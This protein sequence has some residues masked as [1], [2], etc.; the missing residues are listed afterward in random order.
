MRTE[1]VF[2]ESLLMPF[3]PQLSRCLLLSSLLA[4]LPLAACTTV[5]PDYTGAPVLPTGQKLVRATT[6]ATSP[7][8]QPAPWWQSLH[9]VQLNRLLALAV[10]NSPDL[11]AAQARV[12][13]SRAGLAQQEANAR[14]KS[15]AS[16]VGL[17][18]DMGPG[19]DAAQNLR[20]YNLGL[21]ASWEVDLFGGSRRAVEVATAQAGQAQARLADVQVSLLADVVQA[22]ASLRQRQQESRLRAQLLQLD[23]AALQLVQQRRNAG[24]I[25]NMELESQRSQWLDSQRALRDAEQAVTETLDQLAL[26]CGQPSGALDAELT[27]EGGI[28]AV[29]AVVEVGDVASLLQQRPD[30]RSAERQLAASTARI[31]QRKAG[32]FPKLTLLGDI[33]LG[34]T[35]ASKLFSRSSSMLLAA[36]YLSWD[37]LDLGRTGAAVAQAEAERDEAVA[38][39]RS[40]VLHALQDANQ[41]LSRYARQRDT[42]LKRQALLHSA[43]Q[44]AQLM[45]QRR[46]AGVA[47]QTQL[48]DAQRNLLTATLAEQDSR[49]ALLQ[50]FATLHKS[51]GL[52]WQSGAGS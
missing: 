48:L 34:A 19:T 50:A 35:S 18:L 13:Q 45:A 36:P 23:E 26:L 25:G 33:G 43:S 12:R 6:P 40:A 32:Y 24:V 31:G 47:D 20:F 10:Q 46:Q 15:G 21:D 4:T 17:A 29:P 49:A 16:A 2:Q 14:P 44:Q 9:D 42:L 39:Y 3:R 37:W 5:G 28:P 27:A 1:P 30:I 22:Y 51:L 7:M 38:D 8:V 52:G 11:A 41:S